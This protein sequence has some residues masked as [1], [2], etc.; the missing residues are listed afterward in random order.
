MTKAE[1]I[2]ARI[3]DADTDGNEAAVKIAVLELVG[4]LAGLF[5][6][7]TIAL[8]RIASCERGEAFDVRSYGQ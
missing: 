7:T 5:E 2:V 1:E 3:N 8:E 6:R 4:H